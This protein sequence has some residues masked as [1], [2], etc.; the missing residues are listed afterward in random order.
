MNPDQIDRLYLDHLVLKSSSTKRGDDFGLLDEI[1]V[2]VEGDDL[3]PVLVAHGGPFAAGAREV[4]LETTGT[5]ITPFL[6]NDEVSVTTR[7]KGSLPT[8]EMPIS[9]KATFS[10][11]VD[12]MR[13]ACGR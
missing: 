2:Y 13:V 7:A 3:D 12:V 5:D 1:E 4:E 11:D 9:A 6:D 10:V 8:R